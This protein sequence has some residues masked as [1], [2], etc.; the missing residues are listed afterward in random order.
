MEPKPQLE[1]T[2]KEIVVFE[3]ISRKDSSCSGCQ[4]ELGKGSFLTVDN[5]KGLC[6]KCADLDHL[7]W[8]PSGDAAL[9]RR[10]K[11][12]SKLWAVVVKFSR[13]RHRYERQ[14]L[15]VEEEALE[16]AEKECEADQDVREARREFDAE[17]RLQQDA[18]L[19]KQMQSRLME[20]F[21]GCPEK[22]ALSIA[23]HTS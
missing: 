11:K 5:G 23:Q 10:A 7:V 13:A 12:Y 22:D 2:S 9:T 8:L 4:Q 3:L 17:R 19:A 1:S 15:L 18:V 16:Q 20:V 21:P 14:G 6:M